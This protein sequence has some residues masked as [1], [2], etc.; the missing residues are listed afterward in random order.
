MEVYQQNFS[1]RQMPKDRY[2]AIY[3]LGKVAP[4]IL[5]AYLVLLS[6]QLLFSSFDRI[7]RFFWP[8]NC[9]KFP[10]AGRPIKKLSKGQTR[11]ND[12][13]LKK[14]ASLPFPSDSF[15]SCLFSQAYRYSP[16]LAYGTV[17]Q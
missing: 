11:K 12:L 9:P 13:P 1:G 17:L 14:F 5:V 16:Q 3:P 15:Y 7:E 2:P 8:S 6:P 10:G 4:R